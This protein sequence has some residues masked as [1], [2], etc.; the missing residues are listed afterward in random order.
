MDMNGNILSNEVHQS[1]RCIDIYN[2][3][4]DKYLKTLKRFRE[5]WLHSPVSHNNQLF[6]YAATYALSMRLKQE[7]NTERLLTDILFRVMDRYE[8]E[9]LTPEDP[10]DAPFAFIICDKE[11][12]TGIRLSD[13]FA[14]DNVN[15]ILSLYDLTEAYIIRAWKPG[16]SDKWIT[17][18]NNQ[19]RKE[20]Q[21]LTAISLAQFF[22]KYLCEDEYISFSAC[23]KQFINASQEILGYKS[24]KFL[25]L[26]NLAA[27]KTYEEKELTEWRYKTYRYKIIDPHN[28]KIAKYLYI[29]QTSFSTTL[30]E[31]M[32]QQYVSEGLLKAMVGSQ[33][34]GQSF[35][36]SEWLFHSLDAKKNFDYTSIISGYLK[37]IEQLLHAI[38]MINVDNN[39]RISM[40]SSKEVKKKAK[41]NNLNVYT[42][43]NNGIWREADL[44]DAGFKYIDLTHTNIQY[45]DSSIGTFEY[46]LRYN[47]HIFIDP[48]Q[49]KLIADMVSCFRIECRNGYFHTH[50][51]NDWSIVQKTRE[52]AIYLYFVLLGGCVVPSEKKANLGILEKDEFDE[53]CKKIRE[54]DHYNSE[55]IFEYSDGRRLKLIY[56]FINNTI[57]YN[58]EGIEHYSSLLFYEVDEFSLEALEKLNEGIEEDQKV[59]IT[60]DN[61]PATIYGVHRDGHLEEIRS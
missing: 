44:Y 4:F 22:R 3:E 45:M 46:F 31:T 11:G 7:R 58:N 42:R 59:Y 40:N 61:I 54:F 6:Q 60:R 53:L 27:Q 39:C 17:R 51:L 26:M 29:T 33:E 8:I 30:L 13:F 1:Y 35:I 15:E 2:E 10:R 57:E 48:N 16:I 34:Y 37:S 19:Y 52:N 12:R 28:A 47:P 5:A 18:E 49:S 25:S 32:Y 43:D 20:G 9:Y 21:K 55:F 41:A 50:N 38:V 23:L 36:T 56:D 14:D 24:I